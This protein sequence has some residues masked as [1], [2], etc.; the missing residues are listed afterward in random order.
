MERRSPQIGNNKYLDSDKKFWKI[1]SRCSKGVNIK[2]SKWNKEVH[3]IILKEDSRSFYSGMQD[4]QEL[5]RIRSKIG[6]N[7]FLDSDKKLKK[8]YSRCSKG[9]NIKHSKWNKEVHKIYS[10]RGFKKFLQWNAR[11]SRIGKNK[12]KNWE[13]QVLRLW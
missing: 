6:K 8:I 10:E 7:K 9:L 2:H 3:K 1:Y 12:F 5:G 11:Y 13:K 4:I